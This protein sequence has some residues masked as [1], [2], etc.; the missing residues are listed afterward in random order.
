MNIYRE[1]TAVEAEKLIGP[2]IG[3]PIQLAGAV[4]DVSAPSLGK[5][6][7]TLQPAEEEAHGSLIFLDFPDAAQGDAGRLRKGEEISV[8]GRLAK[9]DVYDVSLEDCDF[10]T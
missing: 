1:H 5:H 3:E 2:Y 10:L 8:T 7:V 6:R 4:Y 9:V